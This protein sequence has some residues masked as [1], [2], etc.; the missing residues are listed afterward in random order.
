LPPP[1]AWTRWSIRGPG[2]SAFDWIL[3]SSSEFSIPWF[4]ILNSE[5]WILNSALSALLD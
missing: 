4:L 5:F 1:R 3:S 2:S